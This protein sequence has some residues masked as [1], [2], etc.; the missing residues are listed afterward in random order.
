V[1]IT[2]GVGVVHRHEDALYVLEA[3]A[4]LKE[5]VASLVTGAGLTGGRSAER[6]FLAL[7]PALAPFSL[8]LLC[9][10]WVILGEDPTRSIPRFLASL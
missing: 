7:G 3:E 2:S 1:R 8:L 6:R 10:L 5:E 4:D 9:A